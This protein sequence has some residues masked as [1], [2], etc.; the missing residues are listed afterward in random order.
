MCPIWVHS[1]EFSGSAG[2]S[3]RV[4]ALGYFSVDRRLLI[5]L[6][7]T[8]LTNPF[9]RGGGDRFIAP[10]GGVPSVKPRSRVADRVSTE[11]CFPALGNTVLP[12]LC[13]F[14]RR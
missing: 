11:T 9:E 3:D 7:G 14:I 6:G 12:P 5:R 13:K 4:D 2:L 1:R 10:D 8:A